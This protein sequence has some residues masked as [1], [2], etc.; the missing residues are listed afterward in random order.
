MT[1]MLNQSFY[2]CDLGYNNVN[3]GW[4]CYQ[5]N[6]LC[7]PL[8]IHYSSS[9]RSNTLTFLSVCVCVCVYLAYTCLIKYLRKK[10]L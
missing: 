7:Q 1:L 8:I 5:D 4:D 9:T 10:I 6:V 3:C 2:I